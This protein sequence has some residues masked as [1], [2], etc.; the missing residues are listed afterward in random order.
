[1]HGTHAALWG[2]AASS[3]HY[4]VHVWP[5]RAVRW[6]ASAN[7]PPLCPVL[8]PSCTTRTLL[9][10]CTR[11]AT[12]RGISLKGVHW[13]GGGEGGNGDSLPSVLNSGGATHLSLAQSLSHVCVCVC[14]GSFCLQTVHYC[15]QT[16]FW[17]PHSHFVCT[18]RRAS[19]PLLTNAHT[20]HTHAIILQSIHV[21]CS[22]Y[23]FSG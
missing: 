21:Q 13:V 19:H 23:T 22:Q 9:A 5:H 6:K 10:A 20:S 11:N 4:V 18:V 7:R 16:L 15:E 2:S 8:P 14:V 12:F 17:T 3:S 1:M